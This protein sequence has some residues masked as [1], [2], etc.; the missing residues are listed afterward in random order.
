VEITTI[1]KDISKL[2]DKEKLEIVSRE[3]PEL[4]A[5]LEDF[6]NTINQ[7]RDQL[8]PLKQSIKEGRLPTSR[9]SS[10]LEMKYHLLMSYC[11]D[12]VFYLLLKSEGKSVKE[13]PVIDELVRL[14][15]LLEKLK[16]IDNK[17]K[18][19][20]DRMLKMAALGQAQN[21]A[22]DARSYKPR[23]DQMVSNEDELEENKQQS[24]VYKPPKL[25][26][27]KLSTER[28]KESNKEERKKRKIANSEMMK[29]IQSQY[30][31]QPES[32]YS[33]GLNAPKTIDKEDLER[34]EYEEDYK[35]RLML[36]KEE[37]K[38]QNKKEM[39]QNSLQN[40]TK[41]GD[42]AL[43]SA[44]DKKKNS[45]EKFI[46]QQRQSRKKR[47]ASEIDDEEILSDEEEQQQNNSRQKQSKINNEGEMDEDLAFYYETGKEVEQKKNKTK[48]ENSKKNNKKIQQKPTNGRTEI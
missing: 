45:E 3:S 20:I 8:Q 10:Y 22:D 26:E 36:T 29:F 25:S 37:K 43:F 19:Q 7:I 32:E 2:S 47:K 48:E 18:N 30:S 41:F 13:H 17:L 34:Q 28:E 11:T 46:E 14:R 39:M 23:P 1:K 15:T 6:K 16:P 33:G 44:D 35:V 31:E 21:D 24:L 40:L 12:I 38:K 27:T 5:L 9:G 42:F 4:L